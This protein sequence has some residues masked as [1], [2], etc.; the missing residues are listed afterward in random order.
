M[1]SNPLVLV[2]SNILSPTKRIIYVIWPAWIAVWT[3]VL[4]SARFPWKKFEKSNRFHLNSNMLKPESIC[5]PSNKNTRLLNYNRVS[6]VLSQYAWPLEIIHSQSDLYIWH[7]SQW[8]KKTSLSSGRLCFLRS[9]AYD[10]QEWSSTTFNFLASKPK[11]FARFCPVFTRG[12][13]IGNLIKRRL[14]AG[15][16]RTRRTELCVWNT[17]FDWH[18]RT[19]NPCCWL[20]GTPGPN[21]YGVA[22]V[23][24]FEWRR[25]KIG[26]SSKLFVYS[27]LQKDYIG[28]FKTKRWELNVFRNVVGCFEAVGFLWTSRNKARDKRKRFD[29]RTN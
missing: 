23:R 27:Q 2:A 13:H 4:I 3:R 12:G 22:C 5:C 16:F 18:G 9:H 10:L 8:D 7:E 29:R 17:A 15:Q 6:L 24:L 28:Y 1:T 25:A 26:F 14:N 21:H 11:L 19:E 20:V